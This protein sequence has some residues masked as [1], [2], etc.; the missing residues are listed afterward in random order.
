MSA[1]GLDPSA[2][3]FDPTVDWQRDQDLLRSANLALLAGVLTVGA[4]LSEELVYR[5]FLL[6]AL[7]RTRLGFWGAALIA[8]ALWTALHDYSAVGFAGVFMIGLLLSWLL[9]RTGSLW[10]AILCHALH[11]SLALVAHQVIALAAPQ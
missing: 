11:N 1:G 2:G 4:P 7:A 9:W 5:G 6:S 3:G 8:T 10:V